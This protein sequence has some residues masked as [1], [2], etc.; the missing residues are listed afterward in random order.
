V[1]CL[2]IGLNELCDFHR[3]VLEYCDEFSVVDIELFEDRE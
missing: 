3:G 1:E 2:D